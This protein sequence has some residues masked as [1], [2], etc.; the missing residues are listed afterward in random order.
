MQN[1]SPFLRQTVTPHLKPMFTSFVKLPDTMLWSMTGTS[2]PIAIH[3]TVYLV[4]Q[5]RSPWVDFLA[6]QILT[7]IQKPLGLAP[8]LVG[9]IFPSSWR[10]FP[11]MPGMPP[12]WAVLY[13]EPLWHFVFWCLDVRGLKPKPKPK[14]QLMLQPEPRHEPKPTRKPTP[15]PDRTCDT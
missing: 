4:A 11:W 5:G 12:V 3:S 8:P 9:L 1:Q 15:I 2:T 14:L 6:L 10:G 7:I 13:V